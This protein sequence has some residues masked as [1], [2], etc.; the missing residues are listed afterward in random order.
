MSYGQNDKKKL[1]LAIFRQQFYLAQ[2]F[3]LYFFKYFHNDP[4][5]PFFIVSVSNSHLNS[6]SSKKRFKSL[7]KNKT[8]ITLVIL[9]HTEIKKSSIFCMD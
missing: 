8:K 4:T 3:L 6:F 9:N 5:K 1:R 7:I 2:I